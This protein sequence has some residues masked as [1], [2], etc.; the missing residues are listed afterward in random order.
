MF[1][2]KGL[3]FGLV[4]QFSVGPVCL[5]V[6]NQAVSKGF[7]EAWK[8]SWG[9]ALVDAGY[10]TVS[11]IGAASLLKII[12]LQKLLLTAGAFVLIY[13]G[14]VRLLPRKTGSRAGWGDVP[15]DSFS[16][17]LKITLTNPLTVVFWSG[18]FA[19]LVTSG[20]LAGSVASVSFSAGCVAA[21]ILFLSVIAAG[22]NALGKIISDK[23]IAA[24]GN[25]VGCFLIIFGLRM[26]FS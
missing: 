25:L 6:L 22:G 15:E 1:F 18:T 23:I 20:S 11:F 19:S 16:Y 2:L 21:T 13:F 14:M 3:L 26:L 9:V 8:M 17:G 7:K 24:A 4:L 10:I 5:S 12:W